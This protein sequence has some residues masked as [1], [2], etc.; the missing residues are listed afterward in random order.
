MS[1]NMG[2]SMSMGMSLHWLTS[3]HE[4]DSRAHQ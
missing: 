4:Q 1:M 3:A 2:M